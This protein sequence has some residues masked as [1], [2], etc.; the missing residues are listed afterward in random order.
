MKRNEF[1]FQVI[2]LIAAFVS[3]LMLAIFYYKF[4][5]NDIDP[6]SQFIYGDTINSSYSKLTDYRFLLIFGSF[7]VFI[8]IFFDKFKLVQHCVDKYNKA[9][10]IELFKSVISNKFVT[11]AFDFILVL[12]F[13]YLSSKVFFNIVGEE[14]DSRLNQNIF[15]IL[16]IAVSL[17]L[18][19]RAPLVSQLFLS[20]SPLVYLNEQ[21]IFNGDVIHFAPSDE[22][23]YLLYSVTL[24]VLFI[25]ISDV[26]KN[27]SK[28]SF[29]FLTFVCISL[30]GT[31]IRLYQLDEYHLGEVFT[32]FHQ[33]FILNQSYYS[34]YIPTKGF[35]HTFIGFVND[36]FYDGGY[37]TIKLSSKL[38]FLIS[39]III[40]GTLSFFYNKI[41]ILALLLIGLPLNT[42]FA[43]ILIGLCILSSKR[44]VN[45]SYNFII[46]SLLFLFF[47][48][49]YYNAFAIA[50]GFVVFPVFIY[51][52]KKIIAQKYPP[53]KLHSVLFIIGVLIF[54]ALFDYITSSLDYSLSVSSTNLFYWGRPG[55]LKALLESNS[56]VLI[57]IVFSF[58]LYTKNMAIT[59][60]NAI[61]IS[62]FIIFPLA[63]LSYLEGRADGGKFARAIKFSAFC[64]PILFAL[65][66]SKSFKLNKISQIILSSLVV[67]IFF[68]TQNPALDRI[69]NI[70]EFSRVF[71]N[72]PINNQFILIS[73][74]EIPNLGDGFMD[75]KRYE[76]LK[77]EYSLISKL[78]S[79]ETFLIIDRYTT[80]SARYS[81]F[82]K[83]IPTISHSML[84]IS[85]LTLQSK[86]LIKVKNSNVKIIRVSDG[87]K[88][89]HLFFNYLVSL[90]FKYISFKGRDY[91]VAPEV[92]SSIENELD[93]I[94]K[95]SFKAEYSTS[96]F[97][98]LPIK[99][100]AALNNQL[101]NLKEVEINES[102]YNSHSINTS[103]YIIN[104]NDPWLAYDI[105]NELDPL[106]AELINL[107]FSIT[108]KVICDSQLFWDNGAGFGETKSIRFKISN[109]DNVIPM[110]MNADWRES[111]KILRIRVDIDQC[112]NKQATLNKIQS[113]KYNFQN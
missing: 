30:I 23:S 86:E 65:I 11:V 96:Q 45:D 81:I 21:Y 64:L 113:Y 36:I 106:D 49:A 16:V 72:Q 12:F 7:L 58:L 112:N 80:Q 78:S 66:N 19:K 75:K 110:H 8:F 22:L 87:V 51:H 105:K 104:G 89:Y 6:Y 101:F 60:K 20:A 93:F 111:A 48:F 62:F 63:I 2:H 5:I 83:I 25:S 74:S 37:I 18:K 77:N 52:L 97:G 53:N 35:M 47:Y 42:R 27:N 67:I 41:I 44:V 88:R 108:E 91:L 57:P 34:S 32:N 84:N 14:Y 103:S 95:D 9:K 4:N 55:S 3:A 39:S 40:L 17:S 92:F 79:D 54:I 61:W 26:I 13:S 68:I 71:S 1:L 107:N 90:D 50:F 10:A 46:V 33:G 28:L 100:G 59:E 38:T 29:A 102:L 98:L 69:K 70:K 94:V 99:W 15:I 31:D 109:G 76:D 85:S 43:P 24:I 82:D 73:E 56:W